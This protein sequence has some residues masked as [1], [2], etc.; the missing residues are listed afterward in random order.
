ML[1]FTKEGYLPPGDYE[2]TAEDIESSILVV[3]PQRDT[4]DEEW[5]RQLLENLMC[6]VREL[7][8]VGIT[9][10]Y[11]D[12]SFV[13]EKDHPNDIDGYFE[14]EAKYFYTKSL[15]RDL[16]K[17]NPDK[18]WTWARSVKTPGLGK[19]VLPMWEKYRVE[20]F[21]DFAGSRTGLQDRHG[22]DIGFPEAFRRC[23]KGRV[24]KGIIKLVKGGDST[25]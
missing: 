4:W 5:R 10:I 8:Q 16:N 21:P 3:H 24:K 12:G 13:E 18:I 19:R 6:L 25:K 22:R 1:S 9:E 20:L 11:I 23:R 17:L 7:W 14:V 2:M 15:E